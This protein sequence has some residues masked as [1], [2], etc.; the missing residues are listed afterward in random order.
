MFC[1]SLRVFARVELHLEE[2]DFYLLSHLF[3]QFGLRFEAEKF[4]LSIL[5]FFRVGLY[6]E[7]EDFCLSSHVFVRFE[8]R[9][10]EDFFL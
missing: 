5:V 6:L 10:E 4:Y 2:E 1:L 8:L 7:E 9:L 3:V